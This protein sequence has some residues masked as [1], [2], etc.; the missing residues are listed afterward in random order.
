MLHG[1][2]VGCIECHIEGDYLLIWYD[3]LLRM[4]QEINFPPEA[5]FEH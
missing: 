5:E 2:Y 4:R 1:E 3:K